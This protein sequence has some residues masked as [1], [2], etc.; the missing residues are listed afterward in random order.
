MLCL[1]L[2]LVGVVNPVVAVELIL[3]Q[4]VREWGGVGEW[5]GVGWCGG[6]GGS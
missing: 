4:S 2:F 5:V 6:V 3:G 1:V